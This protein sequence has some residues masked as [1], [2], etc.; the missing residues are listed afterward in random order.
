MED[1][2]EVVTSAVVRAPTLPALRFVD[3]AENLPPPFTSPDRGQVVL[4]DV[5]DRVE[6]VAVRVR[7]ELHVPVVPDLATPAV[8]QTID[9][10]EVCVEVVARDLGSLSPEKREK[11]CSG[12][13]KALYGLT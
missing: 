1:P 6:G 13:V 7:A 2:V 8:G 9:R 11:L 5:A 4:P 3:A 12:N 10:L